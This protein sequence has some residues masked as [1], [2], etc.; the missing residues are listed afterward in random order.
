MSDSLSS[1][2]CILKFANAFILIVIFFQ[3][4]IDNSVEKW[5]ILFCNR[6]M[7]DNKRQFVCEILCFIRRF[8]CKRVKLIVYLNK[9]KCFLGLHCIFWDFILRIYHERRIIC[10]NDKIS[11][12]IS[13]RLSIKSKFND[14]QRRY[15]SRF[16]KIVA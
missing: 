12:K 8:W 1:D 13:C 11:S 5:K 10:I 6:Q 9:T 15:V 4:F 3:V 2:S 14:K 16:E 7:Y